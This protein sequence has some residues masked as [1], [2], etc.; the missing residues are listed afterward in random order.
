MLL[1]GTIFFLFKSIAVKEKNP[2]ELFSYMTLVT[3]LNAFF[4]YKLIRDSIEIQNQYID[5]YEAAG[6][7]VSNWA[8]IT[9]IM[10]LVG[11]AGCVIVLVLVYL[12]TIPLRDGIYEDIFWQI[13]GNANVLE[14]HKRRTQFVAALE[15]DF[16]VLFEFALTFGFMCYDL[17]FYSAEYQLSD[18]EILINWSV[19]AAFTLI[20]LL[21]NIHGH[22]IMRT[23]EGSF[24]T[25]FFFFTRFLIECV[26]IYLCICLFA[27]K[28]LTWG[29]PLPNPNNTTAQTLY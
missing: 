24:N 17:D 22:Y 19:F 18:T 10:A 1:I 5:G 25:K 9:F 21:N 14:Q 12:T 6:C 28:E 16:F 8:H 2:N 11:I 15:I 3:L 13:G 23:I 27:K 7:T 29:P 4:I 26:I 20:A